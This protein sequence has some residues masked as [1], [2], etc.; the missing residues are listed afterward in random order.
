MSDGELKARK[1]V[2]YFVS[3]P[4]ASQRVER[5]YEYDPMFSGMLLAILISEWVD[6]GWLVSHFILEESQIAHEAQIRKAYQEPIV[7][8]MVPYQTLQAIAAELQN[9]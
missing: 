2:A 9:H 1:S 7:I 4:D 8:E 6:G 5:V 3:G